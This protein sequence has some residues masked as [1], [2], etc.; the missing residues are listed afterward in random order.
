[1]K[2]NIRVTLLLL[3]MFL[4]TQLI[5]LSVINAYS[6][7]QE[8]VF[9][10]TSGAV[11]NVTV[12]PE[13]PYGM[14]PPEMK[15]QDAFWSIVISMVIA[16]LLIFFLMKRK[17]FLLLKWWFF[18][19]VLMAIAIVFYAPLSKFLYP[20]ME[21]QF[22]AL[23]LALPLAFY[24]VFQRNILIHNASEL[25]IYP[26]IATIFVPLLN[27]WWTIALLIGIALYD[28]YAVWHSGFMQKMAKFQIQQLR[29]FTGFFVP[30][31]AKKDRV[32]I[33]KMKALARKEGIRGA[34]KRGLKIKV[35][36]AILGGGDIT[37]PLIFAGVVLRAAGFMHAVIISL[38]A[39]IALLLLFVG[40]KK[41]K[42]YPAMLFLS[43]AC[44]I[45]WL[46]GLLF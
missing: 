11:E 26:G 4:F 9:N 6:P 1:M 17:V 36:L 15:P 24:K 37:F 27:I 23:I 33:A 41:G 3:A 19:V 31:I 34:R 30:Y 2:H 46:I 25:L 39:T 20:G 12:V 45:G 40:A 5:G 18:S 7:K 32:K 35:N 28:I 43:P 8:K 29:V 14:Q 21:V 42:F 10:V 38:V 16:I 22:L 44:I 13:L